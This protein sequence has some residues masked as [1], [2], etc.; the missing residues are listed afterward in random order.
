MASNFSNLNIFVRLLTGWVHKRM[1]FE[2]IAGNSSSMGC[3]VGISENKYRTCSFQIFCFSI[4]NSYHT[5]QN[6]ENISLT[7]AL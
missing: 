6:Q 3:K 4:T 1:V 7:T 2:D 5:T